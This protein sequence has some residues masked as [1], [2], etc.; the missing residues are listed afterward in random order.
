MSRLDKLLELI[1]TAPTGIAREAAAFQLGEIIKSKPEEIGRL[2]TRLY[3][4]LIHKKLE[5]RIAAGNAVESMAKNIPIIPCRK[6][7]I[8]YTFETFDLHHLIDTSKKLFSTDEKSDISG[9]ISIDNEHTLSMRQKTMMRRK[10]K[11]KIE[12]EIEIVKPVEKINF[13]CDEWPFTLFYEKMLENI[14]DPKWEVRHG[15]AISLREVL[16]KQGDALSIEWKI[17]LVLRLMLVISL[18]R[19][20]DFISDNIIAPVRET[21]AQAIGIALRDLKHEIPNIVEIICQMYERN[22]WEIKHGSLL[23]LK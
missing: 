10:Q 20:A 19:F 7:R 12:K 2:L 23:I 6:K 17:D 9:M 22:E 21:C 16:K 15:A 14:F 5:T 1:A 11:K 18:D 4:F 13:Q 3:P 8:V